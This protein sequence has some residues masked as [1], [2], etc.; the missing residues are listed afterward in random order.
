MEP[1]AE[2]LTTLLNAKLIQSAKIRL[3]INEHQMDLHLLDIDIRILRERIALTN[4]K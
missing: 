2:E 4:Q 1:T 3:L